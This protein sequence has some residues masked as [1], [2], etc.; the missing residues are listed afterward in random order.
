MTFFLLFL[1]L[2]HLREMPIYDWPGWLFVAGKLPAQDANASPF[3]GGHKIWFGCVQG[4]FLAYS[5]Y[6]FGQ[7]GELY[8]LILFLFFLMI[9]THFTYF[10]DT[11]GTFRYVLRA[12]RRMRI[13]RL[14]GINV[15]GRKT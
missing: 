13:C 14:L 7:K 10:N 8:T 1:L 4:H 11:P 6:L 3:Q 9:A 12:P 15:R 5:F 2:I